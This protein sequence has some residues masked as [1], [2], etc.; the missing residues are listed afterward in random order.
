MVTGASR[1]I[2]AATAVAC[3]RA[4]AKRVMLL[5][6]SPEG[7]EETARQVRKAG[8]QAVACACDITVTGELES[9]VD[10]F[11]AVDVLVNCA[12]ENQPQPFA[13]VEE[14]TFERLWRLNVGA[15]FFATQAVARRMLADKRAG[16]IVN[17]SSQMGHVG[18]PLR[19][20]YCTTKHAIEGLTKA[21]AVELGGEG[22][23]VVSVAPTFVRTS[24]TAAQLE[25]PTTRDQFLGQIPLQRFATTDDV[26][27]AVVFAASDRA[28]LLTGT[29]LVIDGGWTAK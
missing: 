18:A 16:V 22:I 24:M 1:G 6:R 4:G 14:P 3:A 27:A 10:E 23:R 17:I 11:G 8:A 28:A 20:V 13:E 25:D 19:T 29:S 26:A 15:T 7:L 21:L 9:A 5:A 2:G 12:G